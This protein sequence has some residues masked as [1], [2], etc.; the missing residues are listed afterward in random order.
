MAIGSPIILAVVLAFSYLF[1]DLSKL[2]FI[3]PVLYFI[4]VVHAIIYPYRPI[5]N[6]PLWAALYS[7][8]TIGGVIF[9]TRYLNID[10]SI[11]TAVIL[12]IGIFYLINELLKLL[13]LKEFFFLEQKQNSSLEAELSSKQYFYYPC[14]TLISFLNTTL[15]APAG[16]ITAISAVGQA[17]TISPPRC[18]EHMAIY[19]PP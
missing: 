8:S 9:L 10:W 2:L 6:I 12:G 16:P 17:R 1:I 5:K 4:A 19:A 11:G 13:F 15:A 7:L 3:L 18:F 14:L